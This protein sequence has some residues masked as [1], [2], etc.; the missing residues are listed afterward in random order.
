VLSL[1]G[2]PTLVDT[3]QGHAFLG[4]DVTP[5]RQYVY[6][7]SSRVDEVY[8][9]SRSVRDKQYKYIRHFMPHLSYVQP[10]E[11][12]DRAEIMQEFRRLVKAGTLIGPQQALW[13]P[14]KPVEE[15][16]DTQADPHEMRNLALMSTHRETL[17]RLRGELRGGQ[18]A[19]PRLLRAAA[20]RP[21]SS[22]RGCLGAGRT[23]RAARQLGDAGA[24]DRLAGAI[25]GRSAGDLLPLHLPGLAGSRSRRR[26]P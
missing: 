3:M 9:M 20:G 6:G 10:S 13:E 18:H 19:L 14:T 24:Q 12:P 17:E 16:Y 2:L 25:G 11:Y 15:L 22:S 1:L 4:R 26:R 8:E 23:G 21:R 7:A 5:P